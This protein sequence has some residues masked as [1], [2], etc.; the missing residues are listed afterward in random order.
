LDGE[1]GE[2]MDDWMERGGNGCLKGG[3]REDIDRCAVGCAAGGSRV[4]LTQ[5]YC[6]SMSVLRKRVGEQEEVEVGFLYKFTC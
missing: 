2:W 4:G 1:R 5:I 3:G 6:G